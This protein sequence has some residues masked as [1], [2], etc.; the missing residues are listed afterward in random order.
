MVPADTAFKNNPFVDGSLVRYTPTLDDSD[1]GA[2][3]LIADV[4]ERPL[5]R[6]LVDA[7]L[8][9]HLL[10]NKFDYHMPFYRQEIEADREGCPTSRT[11]MIR[12]QFEA[13]TLAV[14]IADAAWKDALEHRSW[15]GM[16][17]TGMAI[18]SEDK[19]R[20]SHVFV[21][22]APGESS[23]YRCLPTYDHATVEKLYGGYKGT[24]V[25]DAS[26]NHNV[27]FGPGKAREAGCWSHARKPF[28]KAFKAG[29][30]KSAA[31]VLKTIQS[32]FR[33]ERTIKS[34]TPEDR[35]KVR[36]RESAPLVEALLKW[37]EVELVLA[38]KDSHLH[39][40]LVYLHNQQQALREFLRN[41]EIPIHNNA[42]ERAARRIVK[43]R[44]NWLAHGSD[45]HA[46]R[47]C[48]VISLIASCEEIGLDPEFY[49][50]EVLTVAPSWPIHRMLELTP[51]HWVATRQRLIAEGRLKYIDLA[52]V[53]GSR[54]TSGR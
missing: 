52:K 4:P 17:A 5:A 11:N 18:Q 43:G 44:M 19:Y 38:P 14:R 37:A 51:K 10:V 25:A 8:L 49:L 27:L 32:L 3:V 2:T 41:G 9:A 30:G 36:Q 16:D 34:L 54:L 48:A 40:G 1:D 24:I 15:F 46:K 50:Q 31:F 33:I 12:W 6:S 21:L 20:Y 22:V 29:E 35:L 39:A 23:L 7:S 26:A 47:A 45:E 13:G 53:L 42:S 28:V